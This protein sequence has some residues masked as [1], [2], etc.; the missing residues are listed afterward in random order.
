MKRTVAGRLLLLTGGFVFAGAIALVGARQQAGAAA[1]AAADAVAIDADDIGGVV[2]GPNGPE[3]GVWVIAETNELPTKYR[4]IVVTDD[5]GR[6]LLPDLPKANYQVWVR[7]YGLVDSRPVAA[8]PG[9]TMALTAVIAPSPKAAA[10]YYPASYWYSLMQVPP[11]D[12]FPITIPANSNL[13]VQGDAG[14][15][16]AGRGGAA[17]G[18]APAGGRGGAPQVVRN[19]SE[20]IDALKSGCEVCHQ[21]GT[22]A[23][24][25]FPPAL[26]VFSSSRE[27]WERRLKVGQVQMSVDRFGGHERGI[28]VFGDW[29]DRIAAGEIPQAP[30]RPQGIE[31]NVVVTEWDFST[32]AAFLHDVISTDKRNPTL[33][34]NGPVYGTEWSQDTLAVVDP[35][36]N[37]KAMI[38]VP[39]KDENDRKV[40]RTWSPQKVDVPSPYWGDQI[41][42]TD[43]INPHTVMMDR[44]GKVWFNAVTKA[45]ANPA[46]CK[47]G[48][49]NPFARNFPI[50]Q[51]SRGIDMYDPTTGK[52]TVFN[53]CF[54]THHVMFGEDK[55]ETLYFSG[56]GIGWVN[57]HMLTETGNEEKAQGWCP[58]IID[59]N[60]DGKIGAYTRPNEPPDPM[61]DRQIQANGYGVSVNPRDGSVWYAVTGPVP[62]KIVRVDRG[63]NP[64]ATCLT[65]VYEPPFNNPK[66]PGK[67]AYTPRGI[68]VD[69][70]GIVWTALAGSGH[71]ASFDRSKCKV[72]NGPTATGQHCVEG[73]TLYPAPGP[74]F[75]GVTDE[76]TVDWFYYNWV[77]QFDTLGL[78]KNTPVVTGTTSDSILAM[79]PDTK[80]WITMRVPYPMGFY[81]RGLDGRIDDANAGWKGRGLWASN[82]T[83]VSWHNEGGKGTTSYV[84]HFQI[85]PDPLAK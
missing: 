9:K 28:S 4:K 67:L 80:Q 49:D 10:Q 85:R 62:G 11:K 31:R 40:L 2:I 51:N 76:M 12:A 70:N 25:E 60:G 41:V 63:S 20:W 13:N 5:R 21:M 73:W 53:L 30:P 32:P 3:A 6:Y 82:E 15:A 1:Q 36:K 33:N 64:P 50:E 24:R 74:K 54:N 56:N 83:R 44:Q 26:G 22:K 39:L 71:L 66:M 14:A 81:T 58:P 75:K 77:D 46:Y 17:G 79:Q 27:A 38:K 61:L 19:Q 69:R 72:L 35:V 68:D 8:V 84:A 47:E 59:Y 55:D 57:T 52:I 7:G 29:T 34:S 42:W 45:P 18:A 16:P 37:T 78:G 65:E 43:P 48:S 23:T